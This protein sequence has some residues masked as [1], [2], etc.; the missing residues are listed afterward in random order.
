[1]AHPQKS[2]SRRRVFVKTPGGENK[3]TYRPRKPAKATCSKCR[4][5]LHGM[6][7]LTLK[8]QTKLTKSK[9]R[10]ERRFGGMLCSKCSRAELINRLRSKNG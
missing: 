5:P 6:A 8:A 9:K 4:S 7:S 1:M 10:P 2:R 3:L